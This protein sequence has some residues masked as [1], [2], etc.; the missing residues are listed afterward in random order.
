[1]TGYYLKLFPDFQ[2]KT[3]SG[4]LTTLWN[5]DPFRSKWALVAKVYSFVRDEIGKDKVSLAYFL[6]LAC[7]T[8]RIIDTSSYLA[9]LGWILREDEGGS[10]KLVQDE[11]TAILEPSSSQSQDFP[12]TEIE[13][14][15]TLIRVG[16]FPDQGVDLMERMGANQNGIMATRGTRYT[17]PVSYTKEKI[18]FINTIRTDPVQA[19]KELLGDCYDEEVVHFLGVKSHNVEDVDSITH[20]TMQREYQD[21]RLFY[22]Y[23]VSHSGFGIPG[24]DDPVMRFDNLPEN[25]SYDIDSPFDLD[26]I[27]GLTQSEGERSK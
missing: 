24:I 13:L 26:E 25:E 23:S 2:Q 3:A 11:S 17:L 6:S 19:T 7:P 21:P 16:Y 14:L 10:H 27:L 20:L 4:F 8:M 1:M 12:S 5:K 15:S 9:A 18:D 22:N